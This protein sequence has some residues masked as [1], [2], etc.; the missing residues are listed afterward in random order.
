[1][2]VKARRLMPLAIVILI[3]LCLGGAALR[4]AFFQ[5]AIDGSANAV[6][7]D[8]IPAPASTY[9]FNTCTYSAELST[10]LA[11][12]DVNNTGGA[13][14]TY[15]LWIA[16]SYGAGCVSAS[17]NFTISQTSLEI[18]QS[19]ATYPD[20]TPSLSSIY[21][22]TWQITS[23]S[24]SG[25]TAT[26]QTTTANT[27][28]TGDEIYVR[29]ASPTGYN[30]TTFG[31]PCDSSFVT[32]TV[33]DSTHFTF[34]LASNPSGTSTVGQVWKGY[35]GWRGRA[36][37]NGFFRRITFAVNESAAQPNMTF[38]S[39]WGQSFPG[40]TGNENFEG[41]F[42]DFLPGS[43]TNE[44]I[45]IIHDWTGSSQNQSQYSVQ[46]RST[47]GSPTLD[48]THFYSVDQLWVPTSKNSGTGILQTY[49]FDGT[50]E[51]H[52]TD[53]DQSYT[54]TGPASPAPQPSNP[55]GTFS[56]LETGG[57]FPIFVTAGLSGQ[58]L[59]IRRIE[60]WQTLT[61]DMIVQ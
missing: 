1:M 2:F 46:S 24:W 22:P 58:P 31:N 60:V 11:Q 15:L 33:T 44:L 4:A 39:F 19:C 57:Y 52:L 18:A 56:I 26:I 20:Q 48:G 13:T 30:T 59:Y 12:V 7:I 43:G 41:D 27:F 53:Y 8:S 10:S 54:L 45:S 17:S 34:P 23:A 9:G 51:Y 47:F 6:C 16:S 3:A 49:W 36:F 55:N 35:C 38:P 25:G 14:S 42:F 61:S 32:I 29:N 50:T 21:L 37:T 5:G 28:V 40:Q